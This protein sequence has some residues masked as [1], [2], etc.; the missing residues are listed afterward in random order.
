[1]S[2][3]LPSSSPHQFSQQAVDQQNQS[4]TSADAATFTGQESPLNLLARELHARCCLNLCYL[5]SGFVWKE[6][7]TWRR[8]NYTHTYPSQLFHPFFSCFNISSTASL[9]ILSSQRKAFFP[10]RFNF[11]PSVF[12]CFPFH[13]SHLLPFFRFF[14]LLL[15]VHF[16][17]KPF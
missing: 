6:Q 9:K 5:H 15:S 8:N 10:L 14:A 17:H 12:L 3:N 2:F 16:Q 13:A 1:M 11:L 7:R 4:C